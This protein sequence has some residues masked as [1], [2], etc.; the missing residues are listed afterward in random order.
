AVRRAAAA[1]ALWAATS[2][3]PVRRTIVD[4]TGLEKQGTHSVGV[5]RQYT[6]SAGKVTNCQVAVTLAVATDFDAVPIDVELY[7]PEAWAFDPVRR[8]KAKIPDGVLFQTK[9]ELARDALELASR[10]GVPLGEV[11]LADTDYGRAAGF[12]RSLTALG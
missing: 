3:G 10:D 6:G 7:L 4:D 5:A 2:A 8:V 9:W 1:W 11:V 12:R